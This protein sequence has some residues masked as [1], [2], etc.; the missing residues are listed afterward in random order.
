LQS[1]E[2]GQNLVFG[3]SR[4]PAEA[5]DDHYQRIA[6]SG[7]F[8]TPT[9]VSDGMWAPDETVRAVIADSGGRLDPRR[10]HVSTR[11][12]EIWEAMLVGRQPPTKEVY[13]RA[14]AEEIAVV[15][16]AHRAGVPL[17]AG[18]DLGTVLTYPGSSLNEE[19]ELLVNRV[20]LTPLEALQTATVN[21]ARF[22]R[23]ER[24]MGAISAGILADLVLLDA[25]PF[26]DIRNARKIRGVVAAGRY[27]DSD[28]IASLRERGDIGAAPIRRPQRPPLFD[29]SRVHRD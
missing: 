26:A 10:R 24:Q 19:L 21:P 22:F 23:M 3:V 16:A 5:R 4:I 15:R 9:L 13:E 20:R 17:L 14:F 18:T 28:A 27:F 12:L 6:R 11:Q 1:L 25:N 2:H 7:M 8:V 29:Q